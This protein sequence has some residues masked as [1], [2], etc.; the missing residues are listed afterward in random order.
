MVTVGT[1]RPVRRRLVQYFRQDT[2][3]VCLKAKA[4]GVK[5]WKES[6]KYLEALSKGTL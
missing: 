1:G 3:R 5:Q 2:V 4:M 6:D